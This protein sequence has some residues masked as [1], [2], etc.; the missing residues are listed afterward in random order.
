[1]PR[2][3]VA[4][5]KLVSLSLHHH[6]EFCSIINFILIPEIGHK[7]YSAFEEKQKMLSAEHKRIV[8]FFI[9]KSNC[10]HDTRLIFFPSTGV[11]QNSA[12]DV[13]GSITI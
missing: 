10:G 12:T 7:T 8:A 6:F 1:M 9:T 13:E 11:T 3:E 2:Q 5:G 4:N